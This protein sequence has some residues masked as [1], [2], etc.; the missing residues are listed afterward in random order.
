MAHEISNIDKQQGI[1]QAWHGLTEIVQDLTVENNWLNTWDVV[2][3]PMVIL[4]AD[5]KPIETPFKLMTASDD[6][7]IQIGVPFAESYSPITNKMFLET[8]K[9]SILGI[10][11]LKLESVGS[12]SERGK[13]FASFKISE[14]CRTIGN[15]TFESYLNFG[16]SH[17]KSTPFWFNTSNICTVCQNT[18]RLNLNTKKSKDG[19][20]G[21]VRHTK[22]ASLGLDNVSAIIEKAMGAQAEFNAIFKTLDE[23]PSTEADAVK[24]FAGF[25]GEGEVMATRSSNTVDRLT[26]LFKS[27][28]GNRGE[29]LADVFSAVTDYYSH[30][31]SGGED[32]LKQFTSSEFGSAAEKK[33]DFLSS[34]IN[35]D[36]RNLLMAKGNQSIQLTAL[37]N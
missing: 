26:E 7:S 6:S 3:R 37:A 9:E 23:T 14:D 1:V 16:S 13:I 27:G 21:R 32:R 8:L 12:V 4:G 15:R 25:I 2:T 36:D 19:L 29:T 28:K 5:G 22:N 18:L 24:L 34:I 11:G 35:R 31:S 17:D 33:N 20:H 10:T 30:E